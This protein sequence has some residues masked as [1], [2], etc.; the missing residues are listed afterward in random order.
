M[1]RCQLTLSSSGFKFW[2]K[3]M[4]KSMQFSAQTEKNLVFY[5]DSKNTRRH[6]GEIEQPF[7]ERWSY[8]SFDGVSGPFY[9]FNGFMTNVTIMCKLRLFSRIL[10]CEENSVPFRC[11]LKKHLGVNIFPIKINV[12]KHIIKNN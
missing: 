7:V 5:C 2:L 3:K 8:N 11:I 10:H 9:V 4:K 12:S 6:C 1:F